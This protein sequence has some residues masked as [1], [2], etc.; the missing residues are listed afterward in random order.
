MSAPRAET[1]RVLL[2]QHARAGVPGLIG[3]A[4]AARGIA[5]DIRLPHEGDDL[6]DSPAEIDGLVLMGG[7][8]SANDDHTCPHFPALL[9]LIRAFP[10]A[11]RPVLGVCLG[12]QLIARAWG[13]PVYP[14]S[15]EEFGYFPLARCAAGRTDPLVAELPDRLSL[16]QW[17]KDTFDLPEGAELLLRGEGCPAQAMR[18]GDLVYGFQCHFEATEKMVCDWAEGHPRNTGPA[19]GPIK[20]RI[21]VELAAH[22]AAATRFGR[23]IAERWLDLL[24]NAREN[25][26]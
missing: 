8:M 18:I 4:L 5:P 10:D 17:H 15:N 7:L 20:A 26:T 22:G 24:E 14:H 6:P 12:A 16:M 23:D 2:L 1:P 25:R 3:E 21:E 9:D 13:A 19:P 11:G